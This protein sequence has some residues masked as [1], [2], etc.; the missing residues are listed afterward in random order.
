[1]EDG[2]GGLRTLHQGLPDAQIPGSQTTELPDGEAGKPLRPLGGSPIERS[3][4]VADT[5]G[6]STE[7]RRVCGLFGRER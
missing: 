5:V 2:V 6:G 7:Y 4:A 1:M 3:F